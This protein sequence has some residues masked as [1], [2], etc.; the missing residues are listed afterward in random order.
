[1]LDEL[2]P[3][4]AGGAHL[5][6]FHEEIH[7]DRPEE[8]EARREAVD[9]EAGGDAGPHIFEPVGQRIGEFEIGGRSG[10][11]HVIARDR[12]RVEFRHLLAGIGEDVGDDAHRLPGRIDIGVAHHEFLENVVLDCAREF[13][14]HHA[15]FLA[16]HDIE[17]QYRQHRAIHRHRDAHLVERDAVKER[18]HVE[19]RIDGDT[20][21]ADIA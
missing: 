21:H 15:L 6:H 12:D 5:R 11:L 8:R 4:Q 3:E 19:D 10:L 1:M 18:A 9:I 17:R 2:R 16:R 13:L 14:G 7:A 20:R